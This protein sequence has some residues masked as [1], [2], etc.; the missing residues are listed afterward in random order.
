MSGNGDMEEA[1][2]F[3]TLS[4]LTIDDSAMIRKIVRQIL[5][6]FGVQ[7]VFEAENG[8]AGLDMAVKQYLDLILCDLSM[9]PINGF[10]FVEFLRKHKN[11][12]VR[13][14]PVVI[15]TVH[16]E[17]NFVAK[18]SGLKINGYLLKPI[19][20]RVLRQ[21]VIQVVARPTAA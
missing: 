11:E 20:P 10:E 7:Q 12:N 3:S 4:I 16:N 19:V 17:E 6:G 5:T 2:D 8:M 18:A 1:L 14:T 15:L 9:E 21:R 13:N